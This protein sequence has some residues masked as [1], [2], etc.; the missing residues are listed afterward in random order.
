M[1]TG[2]TPAA[3]T[4]SYVN[5]ESGIV[6]GTAIL[7]IAI[8]WACG[9]GFGHEA[10]FAR[11]LGITFL[12]SRVY[13]GTWLI[14]V[15]MVPV[16]LGL[17]AA[18]ARF[19][20][21]V[22]LK[23]F[24]YDLGE[25]RRGVRWLFGLIPGYV[26]FPLGSARVGTAGYYLY[27]VEPHFIRPINLAVHCASYALFVI[28]FEFLFRGFLLFGL[29]RSF[30]DT[31]AGKGLAL[32]ISASLAALSLIGL[33]WIFPVSAF[34][35]GILGGLLNLRLRSMIYLAFMHWNFGVWSDIWEVIQLNTG[36]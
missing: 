13:F 33:P 27:L 15:L 12:G 5:R 21:R 36:R 35:S 24:G 1:T 29:R 32:V 30:P 28:G 34:V 14:F 17:P 9:F 18:V 7:A 8:L 25:V 31:T 26:L 23:E 11:S 6:L 2:A 3:D 20:L 16:G 10:R 4:R 19:V 22:P